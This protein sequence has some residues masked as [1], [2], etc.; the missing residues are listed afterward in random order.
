MDGPLAYMDTTY[1][2][3]SLVGNFEFGLRSWDLGLLGPSWPHRSFLKNRLYLLVSA[4]LGAKPWLSKFGGANLTY[5]LFIFLFS[6]LNLQIRFR[7]YF[8]SFGTPSTLLIYGAEY[9]SS[10]NIIF[11]N[12]FHFNLEALTKF[13]RTYFFLPWRDG[14]LS[15]SI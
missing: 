5:C 8:G 2:S 4:D 11:A 15:W 3:Y 13:I 14:A 1:W 9:W 7:R 6:Y 12:S 10:F